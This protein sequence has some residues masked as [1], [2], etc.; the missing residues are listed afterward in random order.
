MNKDKA[1]IDR[2]RNGDQEAFGELWQKHEFKM[3]QC[4]VNIVTVKDDAHD[5]LQDTSI[6]AYNNIGT[7]KNSNDIDRWF[8]RI[9]QNCAIDH[10]NKMKKQR[11]NTVPLDEV[12]ESVLQ[13][14]DLVIQ[15]LE[16]RERNEEMHKAIEELLP[17]D[18]GIIR[19][20]LDGMTLEKLAAEHGMSTQGI[21][22][23]RNKS[24]DSLRK[25]LKHFVTTGIVVPIGL[26]LTATDFIHKEATTL[27]KAN[28]IQSPAR[29]F[30]A[31][32]VDSSKIDPYLIWAPEEYKLDSMPTARG[33]FV[34]MRAFFTDEL[35]GLYAHRER[36][37]SWWAMLKTPQIEGVDFNSTKQVVENSDT[38]WFTLEEQGQDWMSFDAESVF[39]KISL[40]L[41][42]A[43]ARAS[44]GICDNLL[45]KAASPSPSPTHLK[46]EEVW[47]SR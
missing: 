16:I 25:R 36:Q 7:F 22:D 15:R 1:L 30:P 46:G 19:G 28:K 42:A 37:F 11:S 10:Y 5:V 4:A 33:D 35:Y 40:L 38:V 44:S 47:L 20:S 41:S 45:V 39:V 21:L 13:T 27:A 9:T 24:I 32:F 12:D 23:R 2:A 43:G 3:H 34:F 26:A 6:K 8:L 31:S 17:K 14:P 18:A 29:N